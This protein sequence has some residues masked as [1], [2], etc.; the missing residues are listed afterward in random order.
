M[1]ESVIHSLVSRIE[2]LE[3]RTNELSNHCIGSI[4]KINIDLYA[5][6]DRCNQLENENIRNRVKIDSLNKD[7]TQVL[8]RI[9][10]LENKVAE[11]QN[12]SSD[13][14]LSVEPAIPRFGSKIEH[15]EGKNHG[16]PFGPGCV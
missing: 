8:Y 16:T 12:V 6:I 7:D 4:N 2:A 15:I 14:N 10:K 5:I 3:E 9:I 13:P 1:D 11:L